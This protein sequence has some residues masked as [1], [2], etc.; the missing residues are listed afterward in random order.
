MY[1][2]RL[3]EEQIKREKIK[4]WQIKQ[5]TKHDLDIQIKQKIKKKY[6]DKMRKK[7]KKS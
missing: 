5:R 2:K 6:L 1:N 4:D 3:Y 7:L